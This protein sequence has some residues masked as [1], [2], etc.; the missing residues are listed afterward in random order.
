[1]RTKGD[2]KSP[3]QGQRIA[4]PLERELPPLTVLVFLPNNP[5]YRNMK[6]KAVIIVWVFLMPFLAHSQ[7]ADAGL[8]PLKYVGTDYLTV[9]NMF[10][11]HDG[12][13]F[14]NIYVAQQPEDPHALNPPALG[15]VLLK[16]SPTTIQFTDSLLI[17]DTIPPFYL[18]ARNPSGEGNIRSCFKYEEGCDSTFL[19]IC[20]FSDGDLNV[21]HDEDIIVPLC[22]GE[23]LG[24]LYS[25]FVDCQGKLILKY[26]K[27]I[28]P[29]ETEC[30]IVRYGVDGTLLGEAVLPANQ[31]YITTMGV[32]KESPL[33][34]YQW[35]KGSGGHL[36]IYE[37]DSAFQLKNTYV[38]NKVFFDD[39]PTYAIEY[40]EFGS[41]NSNATFVIPDGDDILVAANYSR[42][43]TCIWTEFGVAAARYELRT[44]QRKA[45]VQFN[46]YPGF[47]ADAKCFGFQK[48][49]DGAL[50]L[51]YRENGLS[52]KY[53]MTV[54]KMDSDLNVIW[55][56]YC[57][58]PEGMMNVNPYGT[59]LSIRLENDEGNVS[60]MAFAGISSDGSHSGVFYIVLNHDGTV[61]V[62]ESGIEVRPYC[63]Y[64]NPVKSQL[65]MQFSP[66]VQPKQVEIYDLQ[67]RLVHVQRSN[68]KS[69]DMSHLP[70]GTY[71]L[72]V[73]LEDGKTYSDKV[74]K[75]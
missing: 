27:E 31:N 19:H 16:L 15:N 12:D 40:F 39:P 29:D 17:E 57:E 37:I 70:A 46:D 34:Y 32:F 35:R 14:T 51:L 3:F 60:A 24:H 49:D 9:E 65:Q 45:L 47:E 21:N 55:K 71:M 54:A 62:N 75:K 61:S 6:R 44:M 4:N 74:V 43:D 41:T 68:F 8:V 33:E 38:V 73:A 5:I 66:D 53:W 58:T 10:Q 11:Q 22:E 63:F 2:C 64:P 52:V 25:C 7:N 1:M 69:I 23:A 72:R 50:Y 59:F 56:R 30:H 18:Y 26:Y 42:Q 36:N 13:I 20:H 28:A 48:M 67:G